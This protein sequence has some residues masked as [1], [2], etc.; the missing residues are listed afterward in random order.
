MGTSKK[1][2]NDAGADDA[3]ADEV[4]SADEVI[5]QTSADQVRHEPIP[6]SH[7]DEPRPEAVVTNEEHAARGAGQQ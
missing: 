7:E 5:S 6:A 4:T 2:A 1:T 3:G